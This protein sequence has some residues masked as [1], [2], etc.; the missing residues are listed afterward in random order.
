MAARTLWTVSPAGTVWLAHSDTYRLDELSFG[1]DT[2]RTIELR[3]LPEPLAGA[4]RD[5]VA[6][7]SSAF[8]ADELPA[9]KPVMSALYVARDGWIWVRVRPAPTSEWDVFDDCGRFLGPVESEV[10]L[11]T[12]T[13]PGRSTVIGV[14]TGD[15]D[16]PR[17][18]RLRL[19]RGEGAFATEEGCG[20]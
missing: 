7:M 1:G 18:V 5:S 20:A 12:V 19:K 10:P 2:L 6:G 17:I 15:F 8:S 14:T 13:F 4:E 3:R 11:G 16:V 9:T